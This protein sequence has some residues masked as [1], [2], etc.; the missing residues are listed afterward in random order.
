MIIVVFKSFL[1]L[2][3]LL[4][5]WSTQLYIIVNLI[6]IILTLRYLD[7]DLNSKFYNFVREFQ[8]ILNT[9]SMNNKK[10]RILTKEENLASNNS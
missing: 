2:L 4:M 1:L 6:K 5:V 8:V 7:M 3:D 10:Y 9:L